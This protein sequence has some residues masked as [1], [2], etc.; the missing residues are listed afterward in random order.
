MVRERDANETTRPLFDY[1]AANGIAISFGYAELTP[2]G[3][4]FNICVLTD[5][6]G[7]IVGRYRKIHLPGHSEFDPRRTHQHLEKR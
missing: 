4:R 3:S 6:S 2:A 5:R 1:A 7:A